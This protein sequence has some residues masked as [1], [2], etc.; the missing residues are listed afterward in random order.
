MRNW[1]LLVVESVCGGRALEYS[2]LDTSTLKSWHCVGPDRH[3]KV[4]RLAVRPGPA[5]CKPSVGG[6]RSIVKATAGD[7]K[8]STSRRIDAGVGSPCAA[9][10]WI[11]KPFLGSRTRPRV[12]HQPLSSPFA[13][14][15]RAGLARACDASVWES[16]T[17]MVTPKSRRRGEA[18]R[19]PR[20]RKVAQPDGSNP[21]G[22]VFWSGYFVTE[23]R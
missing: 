16:L 15:W 7:V 23:R 17:G 9:S 1:R 11:P 8:A 20:C 10:R 18:A 3:G 22:N 19:R 4:R 13:R 14:P 5:Y 2:T 6:C 12:S 21:S